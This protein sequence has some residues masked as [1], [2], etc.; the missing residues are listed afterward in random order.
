MKK[1]QGNKKVVFVLL[2]K[3]GLKVKGLKA[4]GN[5]FFEPYRRIFC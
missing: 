1:V 4:S 3:K 5:L 2:I